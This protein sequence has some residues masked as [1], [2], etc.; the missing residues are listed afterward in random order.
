MIAAALAQSAERTAFNRV[1]GGSSPPSG[2][3]GKL[4]IFKNPGGATQIS[5]LK[6]P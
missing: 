3:R 1:V 5:P 2:G 4:F 6:S